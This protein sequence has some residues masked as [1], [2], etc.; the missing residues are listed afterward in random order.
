MT[1]PEVVD[2]VVHELLLRKRRK[3][4]LLAIEMGV[5]E[6]ARLGGLDEVRK[7][8][9]EYLRQTEEY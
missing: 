4:A 5:D 2:Q 9:R 7:V 3:K 8:L 6:L 1:D